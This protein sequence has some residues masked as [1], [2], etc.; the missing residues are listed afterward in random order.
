MNSL[1]ELEPS[2]D[3]SANQ[4]LLAEYHASPSAST[5]NNAA[6]KSAGLLNAARASKPIPASILQSSSSSESSR[7]LAFSSPRNMGAGKVKAG[8]LKRPSFMAANLAKM[9]HEKNRRRRDPYEL[10]VSPRKADPTPMP[11]EAPEV[12]Q[13]AASE[14]IPK[15]KRGR[16]AKTTQT[17]PPPPVFP[18]SPPL[19]NHITEIEDEQDDPISSS[20]GPT[21]L[22]TAE[23][24]TADLEQSHHSSKRRSS[25]H[26]VD[27]AAAAARE[28]QEMSRSKS[29]SLRK[30]KRPSEDAQTELKGSRKSPRTDSSVAPT[31]AVSEGGEVPDDEPQSSP[32]PKRRSHPQVVIQAKTRSKGTK[33]SKLP[34]PGIRP[35]RIRSTRQEQ[36]LLRL[37]MCLSSKALIRYEPR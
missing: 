25:P 33:A 18:S 17:A 35:H 8:K 12:A 30:Q 26:V 2:D 20:P 9:A 37:R 13:P 3:E 5:A 29:R 1:Y 22:D 34:T 14:P 11:E 27:E 15:K 31:V 6:V 16:G 7:T 36:R 28:E 32:R 10:P 21:P 24:G 4:Q 23:P 19:L